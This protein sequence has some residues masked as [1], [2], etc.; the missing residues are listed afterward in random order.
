MT[1]RIIRIIELK[2]VAPHTLWLRFDDG[3]ERTVDLSS[4][5]AGETY[6]PLRD[7]EF[8]SQAWL[9]PEIHTVVWPNGADFDPETLYDWTNVQDAWKARADAWN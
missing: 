3:V 7:P 2:V 6:E 5:L 8:F 4:V 9:D 1:H